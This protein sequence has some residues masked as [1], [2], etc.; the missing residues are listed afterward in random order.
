MK[1]DDSSK[2]HLQV[3]HL[4]NTSSVNESYCLNGLPILTWNFNY[5]NLIFGICNQDFVLFNR[6][7]IQQIEC[8][9]CDLV[10][11]FFLHVPVYLIHG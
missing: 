10:F 3:T 9:G 5:C 11:S 6:Q 2:Q 4:P 7:I 8:F 1:R